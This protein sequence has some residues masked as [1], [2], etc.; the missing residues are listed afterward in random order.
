MVE[1]A[2]IEVEGCDIVVL[3]ITEARDSQ[4]ID[5]EGQEGEFA[6]EQFFHPYGRCQFV[7][8]LYHIVGKRLHD[9]PILCLVCVDDVE[10]PFL[11]TRIRILVRILDFHQ[12]FH[13]RTLAP[14]LCEEF[15]HLFEG[16]HVVAGRFS[17][18]VHDMQAGDFPVGHLGYGSRAVCHAV[19]CRVMADHN[20][21]VDSLV[22]VYL[23]HIGSGG[24]TPFEACQRV[25][26]TDAGTATMPDD[27]SVGNAVLVIAMGIEKGMQEDT[28]YI[29]GHNGQN[30]DEGNNGH[31][32]HDEWV[33]FGTSV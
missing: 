28:S 13:V 4:T 18:L 12:Q 14:F 6:D 22:K 26:G 9:N 32:L 30:N 3:L 24:N 8:L 1:C 27:G 15:H 19:D 21:P 17:I 5:D 16:G 33:I 7:Y 11:D 23:N 31:T 10:H 2:V 29:D 20:N 25:F